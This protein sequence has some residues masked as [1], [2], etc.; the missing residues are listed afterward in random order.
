MAGLMDGKGET[1]QM[2]VDQIDFYARHWRLW[3]ALFWVAASALLIYDRWGPIQWFALGDT[4][5][6]MRIMQVRALLQGQ[7][8]YDLRQYRLD[9]PGGADIHWSRIVDLP[10]AGIML[11]LRPLVG[12]PIAEKVAVAI[13]PLL[14]M[15]IAMAAMAV[16]C[17]RLLSPKAF[18][19]GVALLL[20]AQSARGMWS[21]LRIDHHGWQLAMLSLAVAALADPKRARGGALLGIATAVSLSIGL[22]LLVY[23]A[24]AG[25]AVACMWMRDPSQAPRLTTYGATL[26]GGCALGYLLFASY[27]NRLPVCDALSPVWLSAMIAAGAAAVALPM[28]PLKSGFARL[29]AGAAFGGLIAAGFAAAWPHCLGRL[30]GVSPELE[31]MWLSNVREARPIYRHNLATVVNTV[32]LPLVGLIGYGTMI[33]RLRRDDKALMPWIAL[34]AMTLIATA[35]LL[36][37]SRSGPAAQLLGVPGAAALGWLIIT[38]TLKSGNMLVRVI[39]PVAAFV[40]VSGLAAQYVVDLVPEKPRRNFKAVNQA[41][42]RCP[43]L[44]ALRPIAKQPKGDVLTFVDLNPR[45]IAVTH[46]RAVAGPYHRNQQAILDVM[47]AWRGSEANARRTVVARG[48]DYVLICPGM[49]ESTIY[50][51][52]ARNGFY[53]QLAKGKVPGWLSPVPLPKDSPYRMW[54]VVRSGS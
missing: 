53:V 43:T 12:G 2:G 23:L 20:T 10:I 44:A 33:W 8:W 22:E 38:A 25:A 46:H 42:S 39:G 5:D 30:E 27:A 19:L 41:N 48:I 7:G 45:L 36:W 32:A 49:S 34:G 54:R 9:P 29:G 35:M 11:V 13:A 6:N 18:A 26:A 15:A 50:S 52:E 16:T 1:G 31:A 51:S 3:V 28:L 24:A 47:K 40:L 14:P 17:R 21:P 37:Q 4:D